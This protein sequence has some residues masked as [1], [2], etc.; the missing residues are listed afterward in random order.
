MK[1]ALI[2]AHYDIDG[3]VDPYV[4]EA[5]RAYR[6]HSSALLLVSASA[7]SIPKELEGI[8][9]RF[10]PRS[11]TGYDFGS[12]K[13]GLLALENTDSFDEIVFTNDS[14]YGPLFDLSPAL[15]SARCATVDFWGMVFSE[16]NTP[17]V[18]SWFTAAR[19]PVIL[20]RVFQTFWNATGG[21][22]QDKNELIMRFEIGLSKALSKSLFSLAAIYD[23]RDQPC[24]R[25]TERLSQ[26][27]IRHPLR[28]IRFL[29]K[30]S[31][32]RQPF[33]PS[34]LYFD[35]LWKAGVPFIKRRLFDVNPYALD[36]KRVFR[37][38]HAL[39][40]K[41]QQLIEDHQMRIRRNSN[42]IA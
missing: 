13:A 36:L 7:T 12:W 38:L 8:V 9:D 32:W 30:T 27:S 22:F 35:R 42:R 41:W 40:P 34:L 39:S 37:A 33:D 31:R 15:N 24:I 16:A 25:N 23:G 21:D 1:R 4:V 19:Q 5:L 11:N 6:P 14:V 18:Q 3:I 26:I 20:S 2:L 17:H 10:I 29:K 28:S